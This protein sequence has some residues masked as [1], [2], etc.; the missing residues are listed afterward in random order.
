MNIVNKAFTTTCCVL[1]LGMSNPLSATPKQPP[2]QKKISNALLESAYQE[3][4]LNPQRNS[5]KHTPKKHQ[6]HKKKIRAVSIAKKQLRIRYRWGGTTPRKGFDCSG[7]I[8]YSFKKANI[9]LPR[10][11]ASQYKKTK[12]IAVS[13]LQS[14]DL[15]FFHTPRRRH[16]SVNHVGI[17]LGNNKFIHAPRRGKTVSITQLNRYWKRKIVGAGRV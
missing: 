17:Y 3:L 11:A 10:T 6:Q 16:V 7:L 8:Q 5:K 12:R 1:F 13:Q 9:S 2:T 15:I 4:V 14:G